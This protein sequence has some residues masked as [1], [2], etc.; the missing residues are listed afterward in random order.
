MKVR[1]CVCGA[2]AEG[3]I[4]FGEEVCWTCHEEATGERRP[5][6]THAARVR[7]LHKRV[8][9][10]DRLVAERLKLKEVGG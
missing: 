5:T 9:V 4:T 7:H 1:C 2:R 8:R 3:L 10:G 6:E